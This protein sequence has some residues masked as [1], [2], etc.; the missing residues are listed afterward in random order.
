VLAVTTVVWGARAGRRGTLPRSVALALGL[1]GPLVVV[2]FGLTNFG[3][4]V[5][6]VGGVLLAGVWLFAV[7]RLRDRREAA[8]DEQL[9]RQL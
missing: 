1:T 7:L 3:P 5:A 6:G 2:N 9:V 8:Q 4:V